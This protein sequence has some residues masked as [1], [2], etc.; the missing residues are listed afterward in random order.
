MEHTMKHEIRIKLEENPVK[1]QWNI[2][3]FD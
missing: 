2:V 1:Y 3:Q